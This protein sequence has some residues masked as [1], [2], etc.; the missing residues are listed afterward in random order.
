MAWWGALIGA[1]ASYL[2]SREQNKASKE[3]GKSKPSES[4]RT[5]YGN[6]Y[7]S[8]IFP[9]VLGSQQQVFESRMKGYGLE[10]L[11]FGS[12]GDALAGIPS[13]YSGVGK[14]GAPIVSGPD[15][16]EIG[17][18]AE[19]V[20]NADTTAEDV[21]IPDVEVRRARRASSTSEP[22]YRYWEQS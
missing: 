2:A 16:P 7:I 8:K 15:N 9:Y 4:Y 13:G 6:E 21:D 5:P 17:Y 14:P 1:A 3:A 19:Q 22:Q 11:E 18:P 10:P 20:A 12:Y